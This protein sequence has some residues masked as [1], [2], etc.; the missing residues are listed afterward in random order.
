MNLNVLKVFKV[1]P[2]QPLQNDHKKS[3]GV[4]SI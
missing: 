4:E 1:P 2:L 3:K